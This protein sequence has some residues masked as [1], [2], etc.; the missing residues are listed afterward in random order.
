VSGGE[1]PVGAGARCPVCGGGRV[2][3]QRPRGLR[4]TGCGAALELG[5]AWRSWLLTWAVVGAVAGA[6]T[7]LVF[8]FAFG[9]EGAG[10]WA[11]FAGGFTGAF[12]TILGRR[13]RTLRPVH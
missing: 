5:V 10:A 4:C 7:F 1:R 9:M 3:I 11:G 8:R 12:A 13:H 2:E 6:V